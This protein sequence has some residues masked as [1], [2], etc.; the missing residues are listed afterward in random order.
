MEQ[1]AK[2]IYAPN[3]RFY[4]CGVGA[5]ELT[6]SYQP[7]LFSGDI[8]K[9]ELMKCLDSVITVMMLMRYRLAQ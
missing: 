6:D 7:D 4:R 8:N 5:V 3:V 9:P 1:A 2:Q